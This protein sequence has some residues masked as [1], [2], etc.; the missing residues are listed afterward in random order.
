[1]RKNKMMRLASA[2]LV[3]VLLTTC[4]ISGTF[5][6][7]VTSDTSTDNAR[8]AKWGVDVSVTVDGAFATEYAADT[9]VVDGSDAVIANTVVN[10]SGDGKNL[11]APG[12]KGDLLSSA[13]IAGTPEVAVNVK[14]EATLE[15]TGWEVD[16]T[17]DSIDNPVYYCPL[18]ITVDGNEFYG[19]NYASATEFIAA[20]EKELDSDVN[21]VP[22]TNLAATHSVTW[23]WAF[24]GTDGKQTDVKDTALGD[25]A[26]APTIAFTLTITVTQ[27][28]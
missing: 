9:T 16:V 19:M 28:D 14:K 23:A 5:A 22:N 27:I 15:L 8:V 13:T 12:T 24:A 21:Y 25:L 11:V 17:D 2:L 18:I 1:M 4:A 26:T 10:G 3:A 6:K 7:Y 20:V